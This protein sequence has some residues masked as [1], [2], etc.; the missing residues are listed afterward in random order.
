MILLARVREPP[1][2]IARR[3]PRHKDDWVG[4]GGRGG[5]IETCIVR[6]TR[7]LFII[8]LYNMGT[9]YTDCVRARRCNPCERDQGGGPQWG[10][11]RREEDLVCI[12]VQQYNGGGESLCSRA[13]ALDR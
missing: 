4:G 11:L 7:I 2:R 8:I 5:E 13:A 9:V 1:G 3:R 10:T 12:G 6:I